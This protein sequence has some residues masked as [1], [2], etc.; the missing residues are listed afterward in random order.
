MNRSIVSRTVTAVL[1]IGAL[2]AA[3]GANAHSS[4]QFPVDAPMMT[5]VPVYVAPPVYAAPPA[6]AHEW[7][8][9]QER[10]W[11]TACRAPG[12]APYLRYMP[13][14]TVWRYGTLYMATP[15]SASVWNVNSP[16]EWT[17]NY[18]VPARCA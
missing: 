9:V 13:G 14:Q 3:A 5:P 18:W 7:R 10:G 17:P 16:P 15:L 6:H 1:V 2:G 12:W 4:V 11:R 8:R